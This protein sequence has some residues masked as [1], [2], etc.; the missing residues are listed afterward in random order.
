MSAPRWVRRWTLRETWE[1]VLP[2][3]DGRPIKLGR[4]LGKVWCV[5]WPSKWMAA[6][7][8]YFEGGPFRSKEKA[9]RAVVLSVPT[10]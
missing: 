1:Y 5:K 9:Q 3:P 10:R 6:A 4:V 8:D 2:R 7:G